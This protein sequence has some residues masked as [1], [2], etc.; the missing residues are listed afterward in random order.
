MTQQDHKLLYSTA[1]H[2]LLDKP[3]EEKL[4][5]EVEELRRQL[6]EE[7][8][9]NN[10]RAEE[11]KPRRPQRRTLWWVGIAL[12]IVLI[13]AF[14]LGFLPRHRREKRLAA[15]AQQEE[16]ALPVVHVTT[17]RRSPPDAR[18]LLPGTIQAIT[19]APIVARA[20]GYLRKRYVDIGDHVKQGQVLGEIEAP[21][22][23]QQVVQARA[24]VQ[25]A[26]AAF[27]QAKSNLA[28]GEAN[29]ALAKVSA[30]RWTNLFKRG[31][32]ARQDY[33]TQQT[34]YQAQVANVGALTQAVSA[35]RQNVSAAEANLGRLVELQGFE[36]PRAPF[37]GIVT[38]RNI[39]VGAL[40][41]TGNT[42]LFRIAQIGRLRTF[43]NVPQNNAPTIQTGQPAGLIVL[44][45]PG[46]IFNAVVTRASHSIDPTTRTML[47]EV[48]VPNPDGALLPGM[49]VQ[50]DLTNARRYP[51]ILIPSD[52]LIVRSNG[53]FVGVAKRQSDQ[54]QDPP[55]DVHL[56]Q[57][58]VGRDYGNQI[59]VVT[60]LKDGDSVIVNPN[61]AVREGAKVQVKQSKENPQQ[62]DQQPANQPNANTERL[63]P[64]KGGTPQPK[65]SEKMN[66]RRGPG[67]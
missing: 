36:R 35:A 13:L 18:M 38:F 31:A 4:R 59:E 16:S 66:L 34:N 30:E 29:E 61:D 26:Q 39:D 55:Y 41:S 67:Y 25:Q 23:D 20:D 54:T 33:D 6:E 2:P 53:M 47:T 48:Q 24:Q 37:D 51:P 50:A 21:D 49:Y 27:A 43:I 5:E 46:R 58:G 11:H 64:A 52:A 14:F 56:Q 63:A 65:Q 28:Q 10:K 1:E 44:E 19:E 62:P 7:R 9:K 32:V 8:Q 17:A 42:L 40:I 45:Y 60:G 22:L 12:V 57:V 3:S 15:E